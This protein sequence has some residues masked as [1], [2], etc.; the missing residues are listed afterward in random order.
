MKLKFLVLVQFVFV[1]FALFLLGSGLVFFKFFPHDLFYEA[2]L[3]YEALNAPEFE[4][5]TDKR[6]T[7]LEG[8]END[9][10]EK[11]TVI[12]NISGAN[13]ENEYVLITGGYGQL[14]SKCPEF[15]CVAWITD[16]NGKVV[17]T[18]EIDPDLVWGDVSLV[19]GF[20]N[21]QDMYPSGM[22]LQRNGDLLITFQA[23]N[24]YPFGVGTAKFDK[25]GKLLWKTK[26]FSHHW[27]HVTDE[28]L[29]YMPVLKPVDAP[30][31][32]GN[33]R[34]RV[35]CDAKQIY[36]DIIEVYNDSGEIIESFSVTESFIKSG[37]FGLVYFNHISSVPTYEECDPTHLNGVY[38]LNKERAASFASFDEGDIL[39]STRNNH[40]LAVLDKDTK[41]VKWSSSGRT[42]LQH[43]PIFHSE[44]R[45]LAFDNLGGDSQKGGSRI[46]SIDVDSN[47]ARTVFPTNQSPDDLNFYTHNGGHLEVHPTGARALVALTRQGRIL[48]IDLLSGKA[49]W[50]YVNVHEIDRSLVSTREGS[51]NDRPAFGRFSTSGGYYVI[52]PEFAFNGVD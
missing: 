39:V 6:P 33:T 4:L 17:H 18:R 27:L 49:I 8:L 37:H 20:N 25:D 1:G 3:A 11:P 50:D 9:G 10:F 43:S 52:N 42:L 28:G 7:K 22:H 14:K 23:R 24:L 44:G 31:S 21:A 47:S 32:V 30:M 5:N 48:E 13:L 46:I 45:I 15:G 2:K 51:E 41:L 36:E 29:I 12:K 38:I 16:R 35:T 40:T 19:K 26:N 34:A